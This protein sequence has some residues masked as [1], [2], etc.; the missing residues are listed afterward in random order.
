MPKHNFSR[1]ETLEG[2]PYLA[3][4]IL[5]F[6]S[7]SAINAISRVLASNSPQA[8]LHAIGLDRGDLRGNHIVDKFE[9]ITG[10][11]L[12][13]TYA[14]FW[15]V[16]L[17]VGRLEELDRAAER[18]FP[19]SPFRKHRMKAL[20]AVARIHAL[21]FDSHGTATPLALEAIQLHRKIMDPTLSADYQRADFSEIFWGNALAALIRNRDSWLTFDGDLLADEAVRF[22][23]FYLDQD[24]PE[25][26][27]ASICALQFLLTYRQ[28]LATREDTAEGLVLETKIAGLLEPAGGQQC[29]W[30]QH[31]AGA[32]A[33]EP[34][35][36]A[37]HRSAPADLG[38]NMFGGVPNELQDLPLVTQLHKR[39]VAQEI[40]LGTRN[41]PFMIKQ[42]VA[43]VPTYGFFKDL[44]VTQDRVETMLGSLRMPDDVRFGLP[45][46]IAEF[47]LFNGVAGQIQTQEPAPDYIRQFVPFRRFDHLTRG[48]VLLGR[49]SFLDAVMRVRMT[50]AT[51]TDPASQLGNLR[52]IFQREVDDLAPRLGVDPASVPDT[53]EQDTDAQSKEIRAQLEALHD[54]L[55]R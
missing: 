47:R 33:R 37:D 20:P 49:S 28:A 27:Q 54:S 42:E 26:L 9:T 23:Q 38:C 7:R 41:S 19:N 39:Y 14:L 11:A 32:Y 2:L 22:C 13:A 30:Y 55:D 3:A 44:G 10:G 16:H 15:P 53:L 43:H 12:Y 6:G 1:R 31:L 17:I 34:G 35:R 52:P 4:F 5:M 21:K 50:A 51:S 45:R 25:L 29:G 46:S 8:F 36:V 48:K 40:A 24:F 18:A